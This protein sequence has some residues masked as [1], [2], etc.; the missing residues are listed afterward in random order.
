MP[1]ELAGTERST[2]ELEGVLA[3]AAAR[4]C[5]PAA[6]PLRRRDDGVEVSLLL[7]DMVGL[8][9]RAPLR[10][11]PSFDYAEALWRVGVHWREQPAWFAV[12]C[13]LDRAIVRRLGAVMVRYPVRAATVAVARDRARVALPDAAIEVFADARPS[14]PPPQPPRPLLV[15]H[16]GRLLRIPW[17]E[18]PAPLRE[19]AAITVDDRGL[20]ER[21]LGATPRWADAGLVHAGRVHR[22]GV[23]GR[24]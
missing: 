19:H 4:A 24:A 20:G 21:T 22:C 16:R 8:G 2:I 9:L 12:A 14:S 11:G 17:R 3:E 10:L 13:D 6:L 15:A 1:I 7:F 18:D 5:V 23:A